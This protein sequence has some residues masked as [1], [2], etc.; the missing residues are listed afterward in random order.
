MG[1]SLD[2]MIALS[3]LRREEA[4]AKRAKNLATAN[5]KGWQQLETY[6]FRRKLAGGGHV[7]WW[8]STRKFAFIGTGRNHYNA[9]YRV[10]DPNE[11]VARKG[12]EW[13]E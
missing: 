10:G 9:K 2:D 4:K 5:T 7:D 12:R 6:H 8:P 1:D 11:Y 3:R 13:A